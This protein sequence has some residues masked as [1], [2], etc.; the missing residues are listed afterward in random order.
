MRARV[1]GRREFVFGGPGVRT[2]RRGRRRGECCGVTSRRTSAS[3]SR[4][5]A[6]R[7]RLGPAALRGFVRKGEQRAG[8]A[9][10]GASAQIV[11]ISAGSLRADEFATVAQS[12]RQPR[13][14]FCDRWS[15]RAAGDRLRLDG[16][17]VCVGC[18]DERTS[19]LFVRHVADGHRHT[20]NPRAGPRQRLAGDDP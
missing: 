9:G 11:R 7:R 3:V 1:R 19:E 18:F 10:Q 5:E 20:H 2:L 16:V 13:D 4:T 17:Q 14:R 8:V 15:S 12:C 6:P